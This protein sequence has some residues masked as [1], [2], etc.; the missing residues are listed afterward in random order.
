MVSPENR[1]FGRDCRNPDCMDKSKLTTRGTECPHP[2]FKPGAGSASMTA[3]LD[4]LKHLANQ[5]NQCGK[6]IRFQGYLFKTAT[7]PNTLIT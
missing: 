7:A 6:I 4:L 3:F 2:P 5:K 1:H